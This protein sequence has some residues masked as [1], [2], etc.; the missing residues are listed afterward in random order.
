MSKVRD[1]VLRF[2]DIDYIPLLTPREYIYALL[3]SGLYGLSGEL[4]S[5]IQQPPYQEQRSIYLQWAYDDAQLLGEDHRV[6]EPLPSLSDIVR[7]NFEENYFGR[8][9]DDIRDRLTVDLLL[10]LQ[11]GEAN[12]P[13]F[14]RE[15]SSTPEITCLRCVN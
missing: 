10:D 13:G 11:K 15:D 3:E 6:L 2:S 12:L 9:P 14:I 7:Q 4:R 8:P 1:F 5:I